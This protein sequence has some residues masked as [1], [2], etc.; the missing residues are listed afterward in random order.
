MDKIIDE[1]NFEARLLEL[2]LTDYDI[3]KSLDIHVDNTVSLSLD[4]IDLKILPISLFKIPNL[5]AFSA[6]NCNIEELPYDIYAAS[7]LRELHLHG[8]R[9]KKIYPA[10]NRF[11]SLSYLDLSSNELTSTPDLD[12]LSNLKSL[13]LDDN[14]LRTVNTFP[15]SLQQLS[16]SK[17]KLTG[18]P[19]LVNCIK[20][21]VLNLSENKISNNIQAL[22]NLTNLVELNL[23]GNL[24]D[25]LR[26]SLGNLDNLEILNLRQ[27]RIKQ[28][29]ADIDKLYALKEL[30]CDTNKL[31][32]LPTSIG[33]LS[34]LEIL[35][36]QDNNISKIS[37]SIRQ[38]SSLNSLYL[39]MN[40]NGQ[41]R[42]DLRDWINSLKLKGCKVLL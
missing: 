26:D 39:H 28:L 24:I 13:I 36:L 37:N 20:L 1:I 27:N 8:N 7:T 4:D 16:L 38:L 2:P 18:I 15:V 31:E 10:I 40:P 11:K 21:S 23:R 35:H 32:D 9:I 41:I 12:E 14:L 22:N 3:R 33:S 42:K 6:R 5:V 29:P 25:N 17:N 19:D 30:Y 34:H